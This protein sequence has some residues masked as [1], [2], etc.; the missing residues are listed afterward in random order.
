MTIMAFIVLYPIMKSAIDASSL[1]MDVYSATMLQLV[2]F[3]ILLSILLT[4]VFA[5]LPMKAE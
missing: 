4:I 1:A 3:F 2:P 5:S